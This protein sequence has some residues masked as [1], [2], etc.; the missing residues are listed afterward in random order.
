MFNAI[1]KAFTS[2]MVVLGVS[3]PSVPPSPI[4]VAT[5]GGTCIIEQVADI[6]YGTGKTTKGSKKLLLDAYIPTLCD[7]V[8]VKGPFAPIGVVHGGGF[9]TGDKSGEDAY[10]G[11]NAGALARRLAER[12][13]ATF[14]INYRMLN[15][16]PLLESNVSDSVLQKL[17]SS[18]EKLLSGEANWNQTRTYLNA[19]AV[20]DGIKARDFVNKNAKRFRIDTTRWGLIGMSAGAATVMGMS[21]AAD[22]VFGNN[23]KP[24]AV[25][26]LWGDTNESF[27]ESGE[28]D[29]LIVHGTEDTTAPYERAVVIHERAVS[30]GLDTQLITAEGYGHG[31]RPESIYTIMAPST[32]HSIFEEIVLFFDA[33]LKK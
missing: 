14:S 16:S 10:D 26:D 4:P 13:Y 17:G 25:V 29:F 30:V 5:T 3:S 24:E 31:L 22:D 23:V 11:G 20:E 7:G 27:I 32:D 18:K 15:D 19:V 21:Y 8:A 33:R 9:K 12:G 2:L 28:S 1:A 6:Q